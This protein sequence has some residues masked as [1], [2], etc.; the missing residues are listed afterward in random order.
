MTD[1]KC[2][3]NFEEHGYSRTI[4]GVAIPL[5]IMYVLLN[6][7]GVIN[8]Y[9]FCRLRGFTKSLTAI[10]FFSITEQISLS[11]WLGTT[12]LMTVYNYI[13]YAIYIYSKLCLGISYQVSVFELKFIIDHYFN[14][15]DKPKYEKKRKLMTWTMW[16]WR[17][18]IATWFGCDLYF[19]YIRY[20]FDNNAHSQIKPGFAYLSYIFTGVQFV[21]LA[22]LLL[23]QTYSIVKLVKAI[24]DRLHE[25]VKLLKIIMWC[26]SISYAIVASFYVYQ[27]ASGMPCYQLSECSQFISIMVLMVI[28]F[29][30]DLVPNFALYY[31]H[32][33]VTQ[34]NYNRMRG[35]SKDNDNSLLKF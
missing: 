35:R 4:W 16:I 6:I 12:Q 28:A 14:G 23:Y 29:F 31:C 32:W 34:D 33:I 11:V 25:E 2:D 17:I 24:G 5:I 27:V 30:F 13:P 19:N 3:C 18:A 1:N 22:I 9:R 7:M 8:I 15:T 10:Y 26:F 20:Y 21:V